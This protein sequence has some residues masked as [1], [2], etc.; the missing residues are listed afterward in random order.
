M[1]G[2]GEEGEWAVDGTRKGKWSGELRDGRGRERV[3]ERKEEEEERLRY[4]KN[5]R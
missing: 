3:G 2:W 4:S 1:S 5:V